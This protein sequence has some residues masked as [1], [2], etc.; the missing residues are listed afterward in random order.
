M[1]LIGYQQD[2]FNK[3]CHLLAD[4]YCSS[5]ILTGPRGCGKNHIVEEFAASL[6]EN[7]A[8]FILKGIGELKP[9]YSVWYNCTPT[10][11]QNAKLSNVS[12][13]IN[14]KPIGSPIGCGFGVRF[15]ENHILFNENEQSIIKVITNK[16][17]ASGHILFIAEDYSSWDTASK[18]LLFKI[19]SLKEKLFGAN[20]IVHS[21][22]T[23]PESD[24]SNLQIED[25]D[26]PIKIEDKSIS[27]DDIRKIIESR[28]DIDVLQLHDLDKIIEFT[29][30]DI[31][32]IILAIYYKGSNTTTLGVDSF[33]KLLEKRVSSILQNKRKICRI[34]E[35]V[36]ILNNFFSEKE[37]AYLLEGNQAI[38]EKKLDEAVGMRL[39]RKNQ[40]YDFP[41][42]EIRI[43]F[44]N[45][46]D[47]EKK[48]LHYK[49]SIYLQNNFP[50]DYLNRAYHLSR[51][52]N[53]YSDHNLLEAAYLL[54]LEIARRIDVTG[55]LPDTVLMRHLDDMTAKLPSMVQN[56]VKTNINDYLIAQYLLHQGSYSE[57]IIHLNNLNLIFTSRLFYIDVQRILLL[58]HVLL[59]DDQ[60]EIRR[61]SEDL[62]ENI[63]D[64]SFHE[65]ELWCLA[66]LVLFEVFGDKDVDLEKFKNIKKGFE[67]RIRIHMY[68]ST[69]CSLH[70]K[71]A[72][73]SILFY[74]AIIAAKMTE[75]SCQYYRDCNN[76]LN[77]YLS[78]CNYA[79]NKIVCGDYDLALKSLQECK[80]IT[81][82]NSDT[83]FPSFYKIENNRIIAEFLRKE[84]RLFDYDSRDRNIILE[85]ASIASNQLVSIQNQQG[86]EKSHVIEFNIISMYLIEGQIE[87][88][89]NLCKKFEY[90]Y[91]YLD[92]FY[93][94]YY[95]NACFALCLLTRLH[96]RA[97]EHLEKLEK[98]DVILLHGFSKILEERNKILHLLIDEPFIGDSFDLNYAI[99]KKGF[100]VQDTSASFW[101][102]VFLLADLQFLSL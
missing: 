22:I 29:G 32:L 72:S 44:E 79:A 2:V 55:H 46:L 6:L 88:A 63:S 27:V 77:L 53:A 12:L 41:N 37:A 50:Q 30:K 84:G 54:S 15:S 33:Q 100:R 3:L 23:V 87:K 70:A 61:L 58:C 38:T 69:F 68:Q 85:A 45:R 10:N 9:P 36:S 14:F 82:D 4:E 98:S 26:I 39:I 80:S 35:C 34:L 11:L 5:V 52:G 102:R 94:Y 74:N 31:D 43:F 76:F 89:V 78:L 21:L 1:S 64:S 17:S 65:D 73:K 59:A 48:Y 24:F 93:R 97:Y 42:D 47:S 19:K 25:N 28:P 40:E 66:A 67:E 7:W 13:G 91:K 60:N 86:V 96:S 99:L 90:Q 81:E 83:Y 62:Y 51:S 18:E 56:I 101:G 20:K 8:I 16:S 92:P 57:A 71:Y 75:E 49:F 95:H